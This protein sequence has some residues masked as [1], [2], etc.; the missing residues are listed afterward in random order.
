MKFREL[1]LFLTE[2]TKIELVM[3]DWST[4]K[5]IDRT[6][7][8]KPVKQNDDALLGFGRYVVTEIQPLDYEYI[9]VCLNV[10]RKND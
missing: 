10:G 4:G 2:N 7:L 6:L 1:R 8:P 3:D 5:R 9:K